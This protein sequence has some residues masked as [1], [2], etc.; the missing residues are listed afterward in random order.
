MHY[1]SFFLFPFS[2][3]GKVITINIVWGIKKC[4][5]KVHG[6]FR[7]GFVDEIKQL[8]LKVEVIKKLE[9]ADI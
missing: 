9:N 4:Q 3:Q 6:K 8:L 7:V 5:K 2:V 1:Q